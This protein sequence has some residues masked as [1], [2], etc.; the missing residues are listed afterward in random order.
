MPQPGLVAAVP[1]LLGGTLVGA[2]VGG[3][4]TVAAGSYHDAPATILGNIFIALWISLLALLPVFVASLAYGVPLYAL[5]RRLRLSNVATSIA[6]GALPGV[7]WNLWTEHQ[8]DW[9]SPFPV[10]GAAAGLAYHLIH[11]RYAVL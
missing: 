3:V 10:A 1:A 7:A 4:Y 5:L 9:R 6:F 11:K 8:L 2:I